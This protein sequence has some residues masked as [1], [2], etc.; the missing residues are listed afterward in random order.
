MTITVKFGSEK[1]RL[2][3]TH[4]IDVINDSECNIVF[5]YSGEIDTDTVSTVTVTG[6]N[7]T[8][9]TP[10]ISSNVVTIA[11]SGFNSDAELQVKMTTTAGRVI[12]RKVYFR[13]EQ[14]N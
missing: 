10:S 7:V 13:L 5:D 9:G 11:L 1:R 2:E 12:D 8:A 4:V 6:T 14:F 3:P